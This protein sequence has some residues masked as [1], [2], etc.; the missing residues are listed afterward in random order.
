M[1]PPGGV[2][3][4]YG[5]YKENGAHTAPS[6]EAFDLDLRRRNPE[7]GVR[8]L[9]AWQ[10]WPES[11]DWTSSNVFRCPPTISALSSA[12]R[13][14][15]RRLLSVRFKRQYKAV[16]QQR[17]ALDLEN[18]PNALYGSAASCPPMSGFFAS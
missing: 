11:T 16:P 4:L 9:R 5:A 7:W 17:A 3:Y 15:R 6:N 12:G 18:G 8:D 14:D 10:T 1:L 2:L 13:G